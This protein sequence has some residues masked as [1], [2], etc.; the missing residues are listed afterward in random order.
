MGI[1]M[2]DLVSGT[3]ISGNVFYKVKRAV[4]LGGGRDHH[5][6][7]NVFVDCDPAIQADGRGLDPKPQ[8]HNMVAKTMRE[9]VNS[10]PSELYR[11]R[12]PALKSL[13][14]YYGGPGEN[15]KLA[16]EPAGIP[17]EDN[18]IARNICVGNWLVV[19]WNAKEEWF[20]IENNYT[21]GA[22]K[23]VGSSDKKVRVTRFALQPDSPAW[24]LGFER[25][26]VENIGLQRPE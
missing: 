18:V 25:I 15:N 16:A 5:V 17:P 10:V 3:Q 22:P 21:N 24:A 6:V 13:D 12:Y 11:E 26:P 4:F 14:K 23:F 7:N 20:H 9:R 1:Y 2:D 19:G 8:W